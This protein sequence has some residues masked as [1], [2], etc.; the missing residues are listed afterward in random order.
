MKL[1]RYRLQRYIGKYLL[2][3]GNRTALCCAAP[4]YDAKSVDVHYHEKNLKLRGVMYCENIWACPVCSAL[5]RRRRQSL[6]ESL[7]TRTIASGYRLLFITLTLRHKKHESLA[8]IA[9]M[10]KR[11]WINLTRYRAYKE[12]RKTTGSNWYMRALEVTYGRHGW[13]P[14]YHIVYVVAPGYNPDP[15]VLYQLWESMIGAVGG[16]VVPAA[17]NAQFASATTDASTI[18]Q[19]AASWGGGDWSLAREVTSSDKHG[20][21]GSR[22]PFQLAVDAMCGDHD[23]GRLFTEYAIEFKGRRAQTWAR[24][25]LDWLNQ[26]E[27]E[28]ADESIIAEELTDDTVIVRF[29]TYGYMLL[30]SDRESMLDAI[31]A[32]DYS[33]MVDIAYNRRIDILYCNMEYFGF[34]AGRVHVN[35]TGWAYD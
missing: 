35:V 7:F 31:L 21:Q 4:S 23:A 25:W 5:I 9:D 8:Y 17:F 22:S 14:H 16:S 10:H 1:S 32:R 3:S 29:P 6:T 13:H 12:W 33:A 26:S 24:G 28:L 30:G 19:Y 34:D 27:E 2:P 11:A 20:R 15:A 18:A